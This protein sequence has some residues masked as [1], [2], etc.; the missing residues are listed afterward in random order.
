VHLECLLERF[1][2]VYLNIGSIKLCF[3][4]TKQFTSPQRIFL[5]VVLNS[6]KRQ[7]RLERLLER[8]KVVYLDS[9]D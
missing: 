2:A 9:G 3:P 4:P 8:S 5:Q 7:V 6:Q 1:Y